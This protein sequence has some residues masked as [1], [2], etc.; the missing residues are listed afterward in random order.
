MPTG[1]GDGWVRCR[2]GEAHWGRHGGAGLVLARVPGRGAPPEVLMQR[3]A[4]WT[5]V[6]GTWGFAGG[7][8]HSHEDAVTAALREAEEEVGVAA[9]DVRV[10]A[11]VRGLDHGDWSYTYVVARSDGGPDPAPRTAETSACAWVPVRPAPPQRMRLHPGVATDWS[12]LL[13]V[14][15]AVAEAG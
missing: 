1:D 5:H 14:I 11:C 6:G 4:W 15:L 3:R 10:L 13:P 9:R 2:C 8:R 12:R 7:A